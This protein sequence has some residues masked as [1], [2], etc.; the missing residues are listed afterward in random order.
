M[1]LFGAYTDEATPGYAA[2]PPPTAAMVSAYTSWFLAV[3][4]GNSA[5]VAVPLQQ[6]E[7]SAG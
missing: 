2:F 1:S 6:R 4:R 7:W 3:C 5:H